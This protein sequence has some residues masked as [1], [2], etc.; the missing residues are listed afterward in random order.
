V[1]GR[2]GGRAEQVVAGNAQAV[3]PGT[4]LG[5]DHHF[6]RVVSEPHLLH[7]MWQG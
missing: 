3:E 2:V 6:D 7:R 5:Q 1:V 4:D